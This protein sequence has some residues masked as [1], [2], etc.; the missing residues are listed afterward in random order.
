MR[1]LDD[2]TILFDWNGTIVLDAER[3]R[4][5]L[6]DVLDRRSLRRLDPKQFGDQFRLPMRQ[7]F[8]DLGVTEPELAEAEQEWN[9]GM[10]QGAPTARFGLIGALNE[11]DREGAR[12]GVISAASVDTI[13]AD[14]ERLGLPDFWACV[15]GGA[16]DKVRALREE[17]GGRSH[18]IYVGDTAYDMTSAREAG[19]RAV[20]VAG[21]YTSPRVLRDA[22]AE[23]IITDALELAI[24]LGIAT[25]VKPDEKAAVRGPG[26]KT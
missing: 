23:A 26:S 21:G 4:G 18:A 1:R 2:T 3:A 13:R 14:Q 10:L 9:V 8:H 22:G 19:Y 17:R 25:E 6:N 5:S 16:S 24:F 20:G 11:L 15:R 7:F 12:L